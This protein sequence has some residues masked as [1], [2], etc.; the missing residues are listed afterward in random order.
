MEEISEI[1]SVTSTSLWWTQGAQ[2]T[3][4]K[5]LKELREEDKIAGFRHRMSHIH[6]IQAVFMPFVVETT[7]SSKHFC[8]TS[9]CATKRS[10]GLNV[11]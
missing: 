10:G 7:G 9:V 5:R 4:W 3:R 8:T 1:S 2:K 6:D 11:I